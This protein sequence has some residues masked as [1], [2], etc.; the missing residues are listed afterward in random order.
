MTELDT[1]VKIAEIVLFI[2]LSIAAVYLITS[3]K[4]I[5]RTVEK[6]DSTLGELETKLSPVLDNA[7][8]VS[9]NMKEITTSV[10]GQMAKV[11]DIVDSVKERTDSILQFE[12]K[13]QREIETHVWDSINFVSAIVT[14]VKTF[15]SR[16]KGSNGRP[17][18]KLK[19]FL[20]EDS[21]EDNF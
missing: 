13:A 19:E 7:A 12:R 2:V 4:K 21:G 14:G 3:L 18:R 16:I 11:D 6:M 10:R 20:E 17:A 9:D 8:V 5:T 1:I 15:A